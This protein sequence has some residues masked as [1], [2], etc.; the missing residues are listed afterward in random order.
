MLVSL[1]WNKSKMQTVHGLV[2][3]VLSVKQSRN[4]PDVKSDG[5]VLK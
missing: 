1:R 5:K 3:E 2:L 4:N